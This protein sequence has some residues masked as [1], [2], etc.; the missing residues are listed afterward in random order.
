MKF[1][2]ELMDVHPLLAA[3]RRSPYWASVADALEAEDDAQRRELWRAYMAEQKKKD[4]NA[5]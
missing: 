1:R 2:T 3:I 4:P 5:P